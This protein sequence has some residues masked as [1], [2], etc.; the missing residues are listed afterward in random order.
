MPSGV[1]AKSSAMRDQAT[2]PVKH[3][4]LTNRRG[5]FEDSV[6]RE[7]LK[8]NQ[9]RQNEPTPVQEDGVLRE[10]RRLLVLS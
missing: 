7:I 3:H 8:T 5:K 9:S 6:M 10:S 1:N 4:E 2:I